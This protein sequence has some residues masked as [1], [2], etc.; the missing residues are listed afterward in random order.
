MKADFSGVTLTSLVNHNFMTIGLK[1]FWSNTNFIAFFKVFYVLFHWCPVV[2][3]IIPYKSFLNNSIQYI[4]PVIDLKIDFYDYLH[5]YHQSSDFYINTTE[6][7][8]AQ[9]KKHELFMSLLHFST[10][11][12]RLYFL[13]GHY[14]LITYEFY[15]YN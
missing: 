14:L 4:F 8:I 13:K 3:K 9:A 11:S 2:V 12:E 5:K 7:H 15:R 6:M 1:C 10:N